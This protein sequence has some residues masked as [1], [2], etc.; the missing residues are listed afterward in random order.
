MN[1]IVKFML[2]K[3]EYYFRLFILTPIFT[4]L[5]SVQ[6]R[7]RSWSGI[8]QLRI[9]RFPLNAKNLLFAPL[10][11]TKHYFH[12]HSSQYITVIKGTVQQKRWW[13]KL[14]II[15]CSVLGGFH[16]QFY[17]FQTVLWIR[18]R[19]RSD[20]KLFAG[21]GYGPVIINFRP[22]PDKLQ[23]SVAK[24]AWILLSR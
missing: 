19:I 10:I 16:F 21:S 23:F 14:F 11:G 7:S 2:Q 15:H 1:S 20:P 5:D 8:M 3:V 17:H 9:I 22:G 6:W 4:S 24:I 12:L 18:I 13:V